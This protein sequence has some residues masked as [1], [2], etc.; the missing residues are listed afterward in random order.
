MRWQRLFT[1]FQVRAVCFVVKA[2]RFEIAGVVV[3][4][5]RVT[6]TVTVTR[7]ITFIRRH[8]RINNAPIR[9]SGV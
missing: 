4:V 3:V 1:F 5:A 6:T 9:V 7:L 8:F 2:L